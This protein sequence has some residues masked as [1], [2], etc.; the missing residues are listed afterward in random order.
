MSKN[1]EKKPKLVIDLERIKK[2]LEERFE[3]GELKDTKD[4]KKLQEK[5]KTLTIQVAAFD[6]L[7]RIY[8]NVQSHRGG[9]SEYNHNEI[10]KKAGTARVTISALLNGHLGINRKWLIFFCKE[11]EVDP[12]EISPEMVEADS[13]IIHAIDEELINELSDMSHEDKKLFRELIEALNN[14]PKPFRESILGVA[15]AYHGD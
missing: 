14:T 7:K 3:S 5:V 1:D 10:A 13:S 2:E 9:R 15:K 6:R 11:F 8:N 12:K 4:R